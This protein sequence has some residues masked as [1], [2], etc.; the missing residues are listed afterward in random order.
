MKKVFF[1]KNEQQK[2]KAGTWTASI[3]VPVF[4]VLPVNCYNYIRNPVEGLKL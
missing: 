4:V 2:P 3:M 1:L